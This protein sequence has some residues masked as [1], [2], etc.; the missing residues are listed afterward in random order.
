MPPLSEPNRTLD[1]QQGSRAEPVRKRRDA[2]DV[3]GDTDAARVANIS[4]E[5]APA[6][7]ALHSSGIALLITCSVAAV[8]IA[9]L[10]AGLLVSASAGWG[11][12]IVSLI[13]AVVVNPV[14]YAS[15]LRARER[16]IALGK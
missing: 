1:R 14:I 3:Y 2:E 12:F 11:V 8:L 4:P 6:D 9:S 7:P 5:G 16:E 10:V 15:V 13:M